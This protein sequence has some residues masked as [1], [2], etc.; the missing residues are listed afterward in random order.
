VPLPIDSL[1]DSSQTGGGGLC[2]AL[3]LQRRQLRAGSLAHVVATLGAKGGE[4]EGLV[5][6]FLHHS[7]DALLLHFQ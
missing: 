7:S 3:E 6:R 4:A 5:T 2:A 1:V